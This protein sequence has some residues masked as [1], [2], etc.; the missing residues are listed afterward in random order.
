MTTTA[1]PATAP[2]TEHAQAPRWTR[3]ALV[4]SLALNL[5][6]VGAFASAAWRLRREAPFA[7]GPGNGNLLS[8]TALLPP[9]RRTAIMQLTAEQRRMLRPLRAEV[10]AA[11]LAARTAF[12][13]EPFDREAFAKAQAQ[14]IEAELRAR[15]EAQALFL[16]IAGTL[17]KEE[18][19]SFARW[20]P[21][22]QRPGRG[23]GTRWKRADRPGRTEPAVPEP[24]NLPR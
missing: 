12:L 20:Q 2:V 4:A 18:R 21:E 8:F 6:V 24:G 10:Q 16:A 19:Q 1:P 15:K 5:L 9:E 3:W 14:V 22:P 17:S 13:S 11:R 23:S 7:G